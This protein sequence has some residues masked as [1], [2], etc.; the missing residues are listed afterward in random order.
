MSVI[1]NIILILA[2]LVL[3]LSVLM[4]EGNKQGLGA[5]GGAAETFFG[6]NTSK[7]YEGKL[8]NITRIGAIV[9][10]VLAILAT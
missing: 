6:K 10:V 2:S 9:F 7:S 5:I 1:L 8:L 3:I 4:Q